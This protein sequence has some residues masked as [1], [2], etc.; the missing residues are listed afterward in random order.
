[1][2]HVLLDNN[3]K[4]QVEIRNRLRRWGM[5]VGALDCQIPGFVWPHIQECD[6]VIMAP[7]SVPGSDHK[8]DAG[9]AEL[10][11]NFAPA[12]L[13]GVSG[14]LLLDRDAWQGLP[15][16]NPEPQQLRRAMQVCLEQTAMLRHRA[17]AGEDREDFLTFLGHEMRS[18]L[19]AAKTALEVLQG[20]L[21]GLQNPGDGPDPSLKMVDIALRNVRR[22]HHTV[23]WSQ[24]L[25]ASASHGQDNPLL[26]LNIDQLEDFLDTRYSLFWG[27]IS[28][29]VTVHT[30]LEA[31]AQL[32]EQAGR[33]LNYTVP[34][35]SLELSIDGGSDEFLELVLQ[36]KAPHGGKEIPRVARHGLTPGG[37][38][39]DSLSAELRRLVIFVV[40]HSLASHLEMKLE[41]LDQ[42]NEEPAI[43]MRI[44]QGK[45]VNNHEESLGELLPMA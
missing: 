17:G 30:D 37:P 43:Q 9:V 36:A 18:P 7:E 32:L 6:L 23:E 16:C 41:V 24:E 29:S 35:C 4:S 19:T 31:L 39:D 21:G 20:D 5:T 40:S 13:L 3:L 33:A 42:P 15:E 8:Y 12:L 26:D 27:E 14:F 1:M 45:P 44:P 25:L 11:E 2:T 28:S 22:L 38:N 10:S 34:G